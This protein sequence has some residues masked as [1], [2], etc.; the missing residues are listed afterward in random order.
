MISVTSTGSF[1]KTTKY[2]E[3]LKSNQMFSGFDSYGRRGVDALSSATPRDTGKAASSW[4]YRVEHKPGRH[5]IEWFNTDIEGGVNVAII[6]QY[7]HGTGTGGY[8]AGIDYINPVIRPL[9][10]DILNDVW[11]QVTNG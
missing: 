6:I 1:D 3:Y 5:S 7:G 9:F 2:L 11:R 8:V 4:G 10:T